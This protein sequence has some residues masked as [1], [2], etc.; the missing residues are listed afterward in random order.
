MDCSAV[1]GSALT[2]ADLIEV[3]QQSPNLK[4]PVVVRGVAV[5]EDGN[6]YTKRYEVDDARFD[7]GVVVIDV[8]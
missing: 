3:L 8:E 2:V 5:D 7:G 1:E 6:T 4:V